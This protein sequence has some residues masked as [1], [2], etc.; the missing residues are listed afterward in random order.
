LPDT[1]SKNLPNQGNLKRPVTA[2]GAGIPFVGLSL[3]DNYNNTKKPYQNLKSPQ[4]LDQYF[5]GHGGKSRGAGGGHKNQ[6]SR[7]SSKK[8]VT[9]DLRQAIMNEKKR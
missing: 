6:K 1:S 3:V 2:G 4:T 5:G 7:S 8:R 9:I